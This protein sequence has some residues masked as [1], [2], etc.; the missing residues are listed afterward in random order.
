MQFQFPK[1]TLRCLNCVVEEVK[2]TEV[3]QELRLTD[4][5]PDIGRVLAAWGQVM[6]RSKQWLGDE[7][8]LSGGVKMWVLYAPED[9]TEPRV[10]EGWIPFQIKWDVR[11]DGRE[12]PVRMMPLLR[13]ADG[14][15]VSA[16]KIM[17]RA[18][19]GVLAQGMCPMEAE[20]Y[21]PEEVPKQV[22]V[23]KKTYPVWVPVEAGE[24]TFQQD[25]DLEAGGIRKLISYRVCPEIT[26]KRVLADKIAIKGCTNL[27]LVFVDDDGKINS[28]NAELPFS[29]LIELDG[30]YGPDARGDIRMAVTDLETDLPE[31]GDLRVKCAMVAQYLV[32]DRQI[33]EL[34]E[35]AYCPGRTL[36]FDTVSPEF[37]SV[38]DEK[39]EVL[40][41]RQTLNGQNGTVVDVCYLP[42][43]P[44]IRQSTDYAD[45]EFPGTFQI[46]YYRDDGMLHSITQRC[47]ETIQLHADGSCRVTALVQ[48]SDQIQVTAA[49]D[50]L[51]LSKPLQIQIRT[52]SGKGLPMLTS[53]EIGPSEDADPERPSVI[54]R[55]AGDDSL[56]DIAKV[57]GSTVDAIKNLNEGTDCLTAD[58][59]LLIPVI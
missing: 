50:E 30:S 20:V 35:D 12:G 48:P 39:N 16:R 29:Q 3:T 27:H 2:N 56:W 25:E 7:I 43:H 18:G 32:D 46:L 38:L 52:G 58:R 53:L 59:M 55:R 37:P 8:S 11:G 24:K 15:S 26:E 36:T 40:N 44:R 10:T 1:K 57:C 13:Y 54:L 21:V 42:D 23:L 41:L 45:L 49:S 19:I 33:L 5:M 6:L 31:G 4:G 17:L 9:N 28:R 51:I 22:Q 34:A 14:R 47:E